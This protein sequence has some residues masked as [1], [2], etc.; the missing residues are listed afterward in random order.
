MRF[1]GY[2]IT[3]FSLL[4][5]ALLVFA[6]GCRSRLVLLGAL[7]G[8][9]LGGA[10]SYCAWAV[11]IY[12]HHVSPLRHLPTAE[13][14][15]W[16]FGHGPMFSRGTD[17]PTR[18]WINTIPHKGLIRY[19]WWFNSERVI[20][21]SDKGLA[22]VLVTKSYQFKRP[23]IVRRL[24]SPIL[25][26]GILL[27]E[28]DVHKVQRRN[29]MPA[30]SFRHVK[31][32]YPVFWRKAR[33][34]VQAMA[35]TA[36][37]DGIATLDALDW[38]SRCTLDIIGLAGLGVDFGSVQDPTSP[39]ATTYKSLM[40]TQG[41]ASLLGILLILL[42]AWVV[43]RIPLKRNNV[44][45]NAKQTIRSVCKDLIRDKKRRMAANREHKDVDILS[46]ALESGLFS[47][48]NLVDQ[49]MTFLAAGHDT[50]ASA[51]TWATYMLSC[52]PEVQTRLRDEV[53]ERLYRPDA[54]P[55]ADITS[56]D[57][58]KMPYLNAVCSEVLR[59]FPPVPR[60]SREAVE[61]TTVEG[62]PI[63]RGSVILLSPWAT[64]VDQ[65]LW[66]SDALDFKPER[67]LAKD[68][69]DS[70]SASGGGASSVYAFLTFLHGPR[71]CIGANFAKSELACLLAAWVGRFEFDLVDAEMKD[72]EKLVVRYG[73]TARPK[74]GLPVRA[75]VVPG[76]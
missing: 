67:W 31:D 7:V 43:S 69:A 57:I 48:E 24:L 71:S 4:G 51:L 56:V 29:L 5:C 3:G 2:E 63:P 58:D 62:F 1:R 11:L 65:N 25:G 52:Y 38:A 55:D 32:L 22:E 47:D 76:F 73:V 23:D 10:A 16:L 15:H 74:E 66:G 64:N 70:K 44:V 34:V 46:V 75:R 36:D 59:L 68:A 26:V 6:Q 39:L 17:E 54:D 30:F 21:S 27:T 28:G 49:L 9:W 33:Q 12:P 72:R 19:F 41:Q 61:D 37:G 53:R 45:N 8:F 14:A 42:P 20:V 40:G 35:A 50:T 13:G 18:E 60:T